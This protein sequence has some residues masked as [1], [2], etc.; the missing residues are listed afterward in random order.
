MSK[1]ISDELDEIITGYKLAFS[2]KVDTPENLRNQTKQSILNLIE[3]ERVEARTDELGKLEKT[4][5]VDISYDIPR[6]LKDRLAQLN[7]GEDS[8]SY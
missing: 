6:Y 8:E 5:W 7:K 4:R 1:S 2:M 3:R